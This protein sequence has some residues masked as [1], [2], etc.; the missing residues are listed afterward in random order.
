MSQ[1][2]DLLQK[3]KTLEEIQV[4]Q[5]SKSVTQQKVLPEQN[6]LEEQRE[7]RE[8]LQLQTIPAEEIGETPGE[9]QAV[10]LHIDFSLKGSVE[11]EDDSKR[12]REIRRSMAAYFQKLQDKE[13]AVQEGRSPL[14][15]MDD[16]IREAE[17]I[18]S[19]C[20]WYCFF[21]H[22]FTS[23]GIQ[24]K[25]EVMA[26]RE[27]VE[28]KLHHLQDE[29][30]K[31]T[32]AKKSDVILE[33]KVEFGAEVKGKRMLSFGGKKVTYEPSD[34]ARLESK[35][36][37]KEQAALDRR[38]L[39]MWMPS[40]IKKLLAKIEGYA[41]IRTTAMHV[42]AAMRM[43][44]AGDTKEI[45]EHYKNKKVSRRAKLQQ[46]IKAF[47]EIR[48]EVNR[49]L[50]GKGLKKEQRR[51]LEGYREYFDTTTSGKLTV[52]PN[53]TQ[54]DF[55]NRPM[56]LVRTQ[57]LNEDKRKKDKSLPADFKKVPAEVRDRTAE[58]LFAH[59]PCTQ[60]VVQN[61]FGDCYF[62][63]SVARVVAKDPDAIRNMMK[64]NGNTVTV[65]F[66][67]VN[68]TIYD[69][70]P[71]YVTVPKKVST[72][73][74]EGTLWVQMMEVAYAAFLTQY[75]E[76]SR[77]HAV[78]KCNVERDP[79]DVDLG[80]MAEGG[81]M[82]WVF[83]QLT[84]EAYE[85]KSCIGKPAMLEG[86]ADNPLDMMTLI[87]ERSEESSGLRTERQ[88]LDKTNALKEQYHRKLISAGS[89]RLDAN[90][91]EVRKYKELVQ[92]EVNYINKA[93]RQDV[94]VFNGGFTD[95]TNVMFGK[96][97]EKLQEVNRDWLNSLP[98]DVE[99]KMISYNQ[100]R[101]GGQSQ[102]TK[103]RLEREAAFLKENYPDVFAR[104]KEL[105]SAKANPTK[106][107]AFKNDPDHKENA[108]LAE[109]FM[110]YR[111]KLPED[112]EYAAILAELK[113]KQAEQKT[114]M[115]ELYKYR[116]E[117][118]YKYASETGAPGGS[119]SELFFSRSNQ[120]ATVSMDSMSLQKKVAAKI[121]VPLDKGNNDVGK[122]R[123]NYEKL[124][125]EIKGMTFE[126]FDDL[127][128]ELEHMLITPYDQSTPEKMEESRK[129]AFSIVRLHAEMMLSRVLEKLESML[130][131][132]KVTMFSG[133]YTAEAESTYEKIRQALSEGKY[134]G[135]GSRPDGDEE[136]EGVGAS[137]EMMAA[138][139]ATNHAYS[140]ID[141]GEFDY[142]GKPVKM[143]KLRN[144]WGRFAVDY[145]VDQQG[146][147]KAKSNNGKS[148]G[149]FWVE[150]THFCTRFSDLYTGKSAA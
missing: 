116:A 133:E 83:A 8:P 37:L 118:F 129:K 2:H 138:G 11:K 123:E 21:R 91:E 59:E 92:D 115:D 120:A 140:I 146:R 95:E 79:N 22:P 112:P 122:I 25:K 31:L 82:T 27:E 70:T 56:N 149:E 18:I 48:A 137:G 20:K 75:P 119:P 4:R 150:L 94:Y 144:P 44:W 38:R 114:I 132:K 143:L 80:F 7:V 74:A 102:Y 104:R 5:R 121:G 15:G 12:M 13:K 77:S 63:A 96:V 86:N 97:Y 135:A 73:C 148:N 30:L 69:R 36:Y 3:H 89:I 124:L 24:R 103:K 40:A 130:D 139:I 64:D 28:A 145:E 42:A 1:Q 141:A 142:N 128:M 105:E 109:R 17:H 61:Y 45:R 16:L 78:K 108:K 43:S 100:W 101:N 127:G 134:V 84:G 53:G 131:E 60:D 110:E 34:N 87:Y 126:S 39:G 71:V 46:E 47:Q 10:N 65:R 54:I 33:R 6:P 57:D 99:E 107:E 147:V 32:Y 51:V 35:S 117:S 106:W 76:L 72:E 29:K 98:P 55:T 66:Y 26:L 62:L 81:Q 9:Q 41:D 136:S 49:L 90:P 14:E 88:E 58:P 85:G 93:L 68:D 125:A 50:S 23:R 52:D 67:R 113:E 111:K 19:T